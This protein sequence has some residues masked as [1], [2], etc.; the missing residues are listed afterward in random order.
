MGTK[1]TVTETA[2]TAEMPMKTIEKWA[3]EKKTDIA[4]LGGVKAMQHWNS[5]KTVSEQEYDAAVQAFR[6]GPARRKRK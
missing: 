1:K 6:K 4:V 3:E 5:G 2:G